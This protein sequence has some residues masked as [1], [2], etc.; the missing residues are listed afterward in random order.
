MRKLIY[1]TPSV[2][3]DNISLSDVITMSINTTS[4][5][6]VTPTPWKKPDD[7]SGIA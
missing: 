5:H 6:E 1:K 4:V 7:G 2:E 3:M